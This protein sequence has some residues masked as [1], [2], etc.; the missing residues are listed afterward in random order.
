MSGPPP[1][2][3]ILVTG[4]EVLTGVISDRNGPWLSQRLWDLG[5][6][7]AMIEIV[8]DR[9]EDLSVALEHMR[10]D[11][12]TLIVTSGGLGPT[13]DDLTAEIVGRFCGREMYLDE[14]LSQR[15]DAIVRPML[16]R[17]RNVDPEA[18]RLANVKQATV[19]RG[20]TVDRKSVV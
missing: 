18:V 11:G 14:A 3:G 20:A 6:D 13:A 9:P 7:T 8:G 17:W 19:P 2:A 1:R 15:I 10:A 12:M 4:T 5:V 16:T